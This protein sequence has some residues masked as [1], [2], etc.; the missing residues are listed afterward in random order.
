MYHLNNQR[1]TKPISIP[2]TPHP[3]NSDR[4]QPDR[5]DDPIDPS[6]CDGAVELVAVCKVRNGSA[7][8]SAA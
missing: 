1:P 4:R 5:R 6:E 3:H 7:V 8:E 2:R